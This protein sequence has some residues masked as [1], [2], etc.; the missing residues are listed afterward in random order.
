MKEPHEQWKE[1]RNSKPDWSSQTWGEELRVGR[2]GRS[3]AFESFDGEAGESPIPGPHLY[4]PW[5]GKVGDP[6]AWRGTVLINSVIP[7]KC[8]LLKIF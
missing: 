4:L 8:H 1:E 7:Q 3:R 2:S 6:Q 5:L